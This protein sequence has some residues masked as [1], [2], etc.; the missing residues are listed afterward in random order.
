[1]ELYT[2]RELADKLHKSYNAIY[3]DTQSGTFPNPV[4]VDG[5]GIYLYNLS[6]ILEWYRNPPTNTIPI[7]GGY[8]KHV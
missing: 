4:E 8:S 1:M 3:F 7:V 2:L 6:D 5:D